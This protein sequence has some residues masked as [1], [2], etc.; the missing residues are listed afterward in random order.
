M[1]GCSVCVHLL[2]EL[3]SKI[4][5]LLYVFGNQLELKIKILRTVSVSLVTHIMNLRRCRHSCSVTLSDTVERNKAIKQ[6]M[7]LPPEII[8]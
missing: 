5:L 1:K 8:E 7:H 3:S 2:T 6:I 4:F